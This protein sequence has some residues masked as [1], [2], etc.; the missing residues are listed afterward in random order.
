MYATCETPGCWNE[1]KPMPVEF[2]A[3]ESW[4]VVCGPCSN[5]VANISDIKPTEGMVL[6][7]W[8][9]DQLA[10]QNSDN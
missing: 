8:I 5:P 2:P 10:M 6:P 3:G 7:E 1:Y 4:P 9:L